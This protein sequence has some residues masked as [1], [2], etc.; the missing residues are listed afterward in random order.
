[1]LALF[2]YHCA[3][4]PFGLGFINLSIALLAQQIFI[5]HLG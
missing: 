1:M 3:L 2:V 5:K 4:D